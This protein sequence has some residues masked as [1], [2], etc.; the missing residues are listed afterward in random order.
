MAKIMVVDDEAGIRDSLELILQYERH[1]IAKCADAKEALATLPSFEPDLVLLDVVMPGMTGIELLERIRG[2]RPDLDVIM[3]SG[4]GDV[5]TAI[6]A[7]EHGAFDFIDKPLERDRLLVS[8]RNALRH[9]QMRRE[10]ASRYRMVGESP[11]LRAMLADVDR[12]APKDAGVLIV[13]D[14][15]SGKELVAR[16]I[17]ELSGRSDGPF[18]DVNCA[19]IPRDLIE[20]ELFGYERGAFTGA[21]GSKPGRFELAD[22]GTLFLDEIGTIGMEMQVKL[23]RALQESEFERVGGVTTTSV[24]VRLVAATNANLAADA[25]AGR[26]RE[27]LYYR[28]NVVPIILPPLRERRDDIPLLVKYFLDKYNAR[29]GKQ[30]ERLSDEAMDRLEAYGWPGNIR[31]LENVMERGVLFAEGEVLSL[32]ELPNALRDSEPG[33]A[34]RPPRESQD[35]PRSGPVGPLKE[36]VKAHTETLEKDLITRALE[37]TGGNV[38]KAARKLEISRKSLQNKMKELGLRD[39]PE[40]G[41]AQDS[42]PP[43]PSQT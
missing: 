17:H 24:N 1:Q 34:S 30:V 9:S 5:E 43:E 13:G 25:A 8:V 21:V 28:L 10:I 27:D 2:D 12:V 16:R 3:V 6:A 11:A 14:N 22:E 15:G 41:E 23:L 31:E 4:H 42:N 26:F 20:S 19:A 39:A 29:L 33:S 40:D 35:L 7:T 18:V 37:E 36:I 38:T 32:D